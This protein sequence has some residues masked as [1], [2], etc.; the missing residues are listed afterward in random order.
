MIDVNTAMDDNCL[1]ESVHLDCV[2]YYGF[3]LFK[4]KIMDSNY[5][6]VKTRL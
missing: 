2:F 1:G 3:T 5:V 6:L 4:I